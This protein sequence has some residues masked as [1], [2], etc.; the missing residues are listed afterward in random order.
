MT[1]PGFHIDVGK[2]KCTVINDGILMTQGLE[3]NEESG[4]NCLLIDTGDHKILIDT[5]AGEG[6]QATTGHLVEN[7]EAEGINPPDIDRIIFTHGHIDHVSGTFDSRGS[8]VFPN[9]RYTASAKEWEFLVTRPV[10]NEI[11]EFFFESARKTLLPVR[12]KFD[13]VEDDGEIFPGITLLT[14]PGHT[15]GNSM[16]DITSEGKRLL[17]IGDIIHSQREFTNP[18]FATLFDITPEQAIKTR[19]R[20]LSEAAQSGVFVYACHFPF[21]AIGYIRQKQGVFSWEPIRS[22]S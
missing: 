3:V 5:G 16:V 10:T 4:L 13:L 14:A 6:F 20:T 19:E 22:K 12:D 18:E 8:P 9:A 17:C 7:L 2:Y 1:K 15:P 21:P 11:Q